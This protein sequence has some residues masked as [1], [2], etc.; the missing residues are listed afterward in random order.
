MKK[1]LV[2]SIVALMAIQ[3]SAQQDPQYTQWMFDRLSVN[4]AVAGLDEMHCLTMLYRDQWDGLD[5]D[6]KT[7][8]FNYSGLF[9]E[10]H[11]AGLTFYND[12]L[13]QEQNTIFRLA[14]AY[15]HKIPTTGGKFT[16][17]IAVGSYGKKL[18][19]QW[20]AI[21][22][23]TADPLIPNQESA[24]SSIDLNLGVMY[25]KKDEYY[26]GLSSTH[27]TE[28]DL[29]S[30][31]ITVARHYYFMG[32][33]NFALGSPDLTLRTNVLAKSD[34]NASIFDL[35]AN[36]L[37]TQ[38]NWGVWGGLSFRPSDA[39][40][41]MLGFETSWSKD[42][43]QGT[44][45]NQKLMLGYSFDATTSDIKNYSAGSHEIFVTYCF[46]IQRII[47]LNKHGNPRFL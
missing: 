18:G 25:S 29:S 40:A 38:S 35:N 19:N 33:Y 16:A 23:Y 41:P 39:I 27:L 5:K 37:Y 22:D 10:K 28:A 30:L 34:F 45:T 9:A 8:L 42:D 1:C 21:D 17:G 20:I 46:N 12:V 31:S 2:A 15:H 32:G 14:Y 47:L 36:V 4:P 3:V 24:A 6:P 11:G 44:K 26:V 7:A 13:G 43:G